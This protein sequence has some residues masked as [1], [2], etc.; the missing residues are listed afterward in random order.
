MNFGACFLSRD[1]PS[2]DNLVVRNT[3]IEW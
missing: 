1:F 2:L 3:F